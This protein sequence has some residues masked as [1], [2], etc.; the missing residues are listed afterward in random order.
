[1]VTIAKQLGKRNASGD[2]GIELELEF[3]NESPTVELSNYDDWTIH[4]EGSLRGH[5]LELVSSYPFKVDNNLAS[6]IK[7]VCD[8]INKPRYGVI[9]DSDRTSCHVHVNML[10]ATPLQTMTMAVCYWILEEPLF[11]LC[12]PSRKGNHFCLRLSDAEMIIP[13]LRKRIND[14]VIFAKGF[15]GDSIR[16]SALNFASLSKFGTLEFRGMR[17]LTSANEIEEWVRIVFDIKKISK[18][19]K[20]PEEVLDFLARHS[21]LDFMNMFFSPDIVRRMTRSPNYEKGMKD[22]LYRLCGLVY[23]TDWS[24]WS[25]DTDESIKKSKIPMYAI[26]GIFDDVVINDNNFNLNVEDFPV[27]AAP[28]ANQNNNINDPRPILPN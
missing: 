13:T 19:F 27:R 17:G 24:S 23:N 20:D 22:N 1:M 26:N 25:R 18:S 5:A 7:S 6:L 16:Y 9:K 10:N 28:K 3:Q 12:G 11:E 2:V 14:R 8:V 21:Y 15:Q 4:P